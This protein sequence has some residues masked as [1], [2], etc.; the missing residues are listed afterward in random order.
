[1]SYTLY[2]APGAASMAVHW[3]LIELGVPFD[4]VLVDINAGAQ[5]SADYLKLN[6]AGRVPTLVVD[7][8]A[9]TESTALLMLLA[10]RHPAAAMMPLPGTPHRAAWL[11]L[12]IYLANTV[13]PA[14]RDWFYAGKDGDASGADAVSALARRRIEGAWDQLDQ[15]LASGQPFLVGPH[16]TTADLLAVMLMRWSRGMPRPAT[17]W[18]A[19][20]GYVERICATPG[21]VEVCR[22]EGLSGWPPPRA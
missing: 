16:R 17:G 20:A 8:V 2:Y 14:M 9:Y 12:M 5:R 15:R 1:M 6:P 18:P 7:S 3:M 22:R 21:F 11:E 4:T 10:E 13:L 19:L